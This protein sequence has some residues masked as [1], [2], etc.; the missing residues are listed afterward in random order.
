M[1]K[2]KT[3]INIHAKRYIQEVFENRLREEGFTCPDDKLLCWY[4]VKNQELLNTIIFYSSWPQMPLFLQIGHEFTPLFTEPIYIKNVNFNASLNFRHDIFWSKQNLE[5]LAKHAENLRPYSPDSWVYAPGHGG[6]G[7]YTFDEVLLPMFEQTETI[8]DCYTSHKQYHLEKKPR[9][10]SSLFGE[11]SREFIDEAI[12]LDDVEVYPYCKARIER[13]LNLY[14]ILVEK[15]P[16]DKA[17]KDALDHW[18]KLKIALLDGERKAYLDSLEL[19][20][21]KNIAKLHK[22]FGISL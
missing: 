10:G 7:I 22:K 16:N 9:F 11:A 5:S 20:K 8:E 2:N 18:T 4:R 14:T 17:L 13:A 15:K 3:V 1:A 6:R 19:R 12:Y 21:A